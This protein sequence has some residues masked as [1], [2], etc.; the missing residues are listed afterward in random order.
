M[1]A[2]REMRV[3]VVW[4]REENRLPGSH[5]KGGLIERDQ[6]SLG[7]RITLSVK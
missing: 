2:R 6:Y 4:R 7:S 1:I 5:R 3:A